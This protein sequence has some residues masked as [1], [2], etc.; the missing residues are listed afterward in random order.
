M[1]DRADDVGNLLV[2]VYEIHEIIITE[3]GGLPGFREATL[4]HAAVARPFTTFGGEELYA[5]DFDKAAALFHSL[6]KSH[7]FMD[8]TKR[9]AFA[10]ALFFLESLGH[11]IPKQFPLDEVVDFCVAVAEENMRQS[12]GEPIAPYTIPEI[13]DWFRTLLR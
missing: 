2:R 12:Q 6:I 3:T 4:L 10:A 1:E 8:G 11:S 7:P 9:T 5:T 13:A